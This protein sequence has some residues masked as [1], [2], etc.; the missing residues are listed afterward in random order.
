[1]I[2]LRRAAVSDVRG[3]G[4]VVHDV[5]GQ[6]ILPDVCRAQIGDDDCE[7]RIAERGGN[8]LGFISAFLTVDR[9]GDRRWEVDLVAV[10]PD[11][12]G[13]G[14]GKR[15]IRR[16]G[17]DAVKQGVA[18]TR[19]LIRVSNSPSQ[20]AFER[21]G[22][23]TDRRVHHLLLWS[24]KVAEG[25][26]PCLEDVSLSPVETLT[27]RGLWIE[28]LEEIAASKQR[29]VVDAAR[30]IAA[31]ENRLNTGA[32]IPA[33]KNHLLAAD[34]CSQAELQGDYYWFIKHSSGERE[35]RTPKHP[36]A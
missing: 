13:R 31:R 29:L 36:V 12:Q 28:R 34:L 9:D 32:V 6:E 14:L 25:P 7:L 22:F 30:A 2:D 8:V 18:V 4:S 21:A 35:A 10:R 23:A 27:Y 15:L 5:W 33:D 1:M 19:A 20:K 26:A 11:Q 16:A 24:P 3:I 17:E